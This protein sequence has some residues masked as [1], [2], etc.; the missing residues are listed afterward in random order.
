MFLVAEVLFENAYKTCVSETLG[1]ARE[2]NG[3]WE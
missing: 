1:F 2:P 3:I